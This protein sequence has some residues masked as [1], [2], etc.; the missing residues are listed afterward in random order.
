MAVA[1]RPGC[2]RLAV[3]LYGKIHL[4]DLGKQLELE[5]PTSHPAWIFCMAYGP[6]GKYLAAGDGKGNLKLWRTEKR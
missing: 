3:G 5:P 6:G 2:G 4:W 1:F